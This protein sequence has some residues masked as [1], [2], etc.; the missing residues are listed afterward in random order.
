[1]D[2]YIYT[3]YGYSGI[4]DYDATK[5]TLEKAAADAGVSVMS[6][7]AQNSGIFTGADKCWSGVSL[8]TRGEGA[9]ATN[10]LTFNLLLNIKGKNWKKMYVARP[11]ITYIYHGVTY[12]VYDGGDTATSTIYSHCSVYYLADYFVTYCVDPISGLP[13][14]GYER[15]VNY[16]NDRIISHGSELP[17]GD[18]EQQQSRGVIDP[19]GGGGG[20]G[21]DDDPFAF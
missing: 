20:S 8:H 5:L 19:Q 9:S 6:V 4:A 14:P 7:P 21:E 18:W 15:I 17:D 1:M 12:T 10:S 11:Y 13:Y 3:Q 16:C 2:G